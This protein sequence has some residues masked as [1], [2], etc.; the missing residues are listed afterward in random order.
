MSSENPDSRY[1]PQILLDKIGEEGQR[2][3]GAGK[4][5]LVGCG[6][7]GS[8]VISVLVRAGVGQVTVLDADR[9]EMSNLGRQILYNEDD[10]ASGRHKVEAA[11]DRLARINANVEVRAL[12]ERFEAHNAA[13]LVAGAD[14]VVDGTDNFEARYL[15][16][17]TCVSQGKPWIYGGVVGTSGLRL[18]VVPGQGPCLRCLFPAA[19]EPGA[20]PH[21][22]THGILGTLPMV[23]AALQ[24]TEAIK[25][26]VGAP[27]ATGLL[28]MDL[29]EPSFQQIKTR[30][31]PACPVCAGHVTKLDMQK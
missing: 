27:A 28:T 2:R 25:L 1:D 10:V 21:P 14:L 19:P 16:N 3:L 7:L 23:V 30:R 24:A 5:L 15:I 13:E 6:G 31:D 17:D 12:V 9:V 22:S 29:W 11:R 8:M 20:L 4:V 26:L 18:T